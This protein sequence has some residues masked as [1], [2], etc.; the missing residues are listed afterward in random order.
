[1]DGPPPVPGG[2]S[3]QEREAARLEREARR[4]SGGDAPAVPP[5][6]TPPPAPSTG[7]GR[8]WLDDAR[9]LTE[10]GDGNGRGPGGAPGSPDRGGPRWGR[11]A[12]VLVAGVVAL[13]VAWFL[14]SLFQPFK[15][16]GG[17]RVRVNVPR[18]SSLEQIAKLLEKEDVV[19]SSTFFQ[20]RAR[21]AGRSDGLKPGSYTLRKDMSFS[22]A[23]DALEKGTSPNIVDI[24][25]P[26][27]LSRAEIAK[28]TKGRLP[29][30]YL[31][32]TR[33]SRL[34]D[35]RDYRA[36]GAT[37]LEGF[38]FP[39]TYE[40]RRGQSVRR[41]VERQLTTF[42]QRFRSV[43]LRK[44][45]TKNLTPWDVLIIASMVERE[46]QIPRERRLIASVIYNRL[47]EGIPLGIDATL[48]FETG[49]WDRPL[50]VSQLQAATPYNTRVNA[51]LPPGPIG[52]PGL[53]SIRAAAN[54]ART[55]YLY[56]VVKPCGRGRHAFAVTDAQ[57]QRNVDA[58]NR[59][60]AKHG[61]NSPVDC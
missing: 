46:A 29:G 52:N 2:R 11:F 35:P 33:R 14:I 3:A 18:G 25:I 49:N 24:T 41:L 34:L 47:H 9:R 55:K 58:Y 42:K 39:A 15:G 7:P 28:I 4:A 32:A 31:A 16:D 53:A 50:R 27:G 22:A 44:A 5:P 56:Y 26:E 12:A 17:E 1:M 59:A 48:R 57:H 13:A 61:G 54:P 45:R 43:S 19:S 30:S 10:T 8:D 21:L 6:P 60:R 37:S 40:L 38:L 51:G 20:L 23:L 36:K